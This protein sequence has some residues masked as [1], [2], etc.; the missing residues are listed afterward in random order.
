[1]LIY[2]AVPQSDFIFSSEDFRAGELVTH[3]QSCIWLVGYSDLGRA[4]LSFGP[5]GKPVDAHGALAATVL[6]I[7]YEE[8]LKQAKD[9]ATKKRCKDA[10]QASKPPNFGFPG[11]MGPVKLV[12]QQ[13]EQGPDTPCPNGPS[14]IKDGD[15]D[16]PGYKGLRFC[17]LMDGAPHCGVRAN[18]EPGKTNEYNDKPIPPTCIH[19][20]ECAVRLK[21]IWKRQWSE[22]GPYFDYVNECCKKG[23]LITPHALERW[24]WLKEWYKPW[25]QLAPGEIM[26][27]VTGRI[28]GGLADDYCAACNGFFQGLL[29]DIAK[30]AHRQCVRECYD[31]TYRVPAFLH[32]NSLQS[33]F[34]G[35]ESPLFGSRIPV[36]QHDELIGEHP[37]SVASEGALRISE[38]M[39]DKLRYRCPDLADAAAAEPTLMEKWFKGAEITWQHGL[40]LPD[41]KR[42]KSQRA[43]D[44]RDRLVPWQPKI[45][46]AKVAA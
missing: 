13:R 18:G 32:E 4:L 6:G 10:R 31:R 30:E 43:T 12:L 42:D 33:E 15:K 3:S 29:A 37:R 9:P 45:G 40:L 11:G 7:S 27:H 17:I 22:S 2:R 26:Q 23:M 19:C 21:A 14:T 16:V 28:R 41:G 20:I 39:R 25:Q 34:A 36:F 8:F 46:P 1:V 5:D 24:P 44:V 38:V 35:G